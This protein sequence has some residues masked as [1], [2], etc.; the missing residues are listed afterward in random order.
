[1]S[2]YTEVTQALAKMAHLEQVVQQVQVSSARTEEQLSNIEEKL[3]SQDETLDE[4]VKL[5]QFNTE[6]LKEHM[7]RTAANEAQL[8]V[9]E[10]ELAE[11]RKLKYYLTGG[12]IVV[13]ALNTPLGQ[14]AAKLLE[15]ITKGN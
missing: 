2:L 14:V 11:F 5:T 12:L 9:M 13:G 7:R 10:K 6:N 4:L 8:G 1:M 15:S 3:E